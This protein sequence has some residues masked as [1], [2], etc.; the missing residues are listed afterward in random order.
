MILKYDKLFGVVPK[1]KQEIL[2]GQSYMGVYEKYIEL[3]GG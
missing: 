3:I 1:A 2:S